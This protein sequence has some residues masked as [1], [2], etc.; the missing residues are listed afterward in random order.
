MQM[1][2]YQLPVSRTFYAT[3]D[4]PEDEDAP[5]TQVN[6]LRHWLIYPDGRIF[7]QDE[8]LTSR[9]GVMQSS[10]R[11]DWEQLPTP[12]QMESV[13]GTFEYGGLPGVVTVSG[14][15]YLW[16]SKQPDNEEEEGLIRVLSQEHRI[17]DWPH[18][19]VPFNEPV[20]GTPAF[21]E[22]NR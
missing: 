11:T 10:T 20:P 8:T 22:Y 14:K 18:M 1:L 4:D 6:V 7:F 13:A 19:W 21:K 2:I 12:P 17:H 9:D 15:A 5:Y 3:G 16:A